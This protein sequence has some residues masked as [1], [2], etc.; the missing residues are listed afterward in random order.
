MI[1]R[2]MEFSPNNI[3]K[4]EH[5]G[6][7]RSFLGSSVDENITK[8]YADEHAAFHK[9]AGHVLPD[10]FL[11]LQTLHTAFWTSHSGKMLPVGLVRDLL[12]TTS[13]LNWRTPYTHEAIHDVSAVGQKRVM[14][15]SVHLRV[16]LLKERRILL[17]LCRSILL[18]EKLDDSHCQIVQNTMN[19]FGSNDP[20]QALWGFQMSK[21]SKHERK[22]T[23]PCNPTYHY[24]V[25]HALSSA[26]LEHRSRHDRAIFEAILFE[27]LNNVNLR[28]ES[29]QPKL[30][31]YPDAI[32]E[33]QRLEM[34][35]LLRLGN[36]S[37]ITQS[38]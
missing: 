15:A 23:K 28:I 21:T 29:H 33:L 4:N 18:E 31:E 26:H 12:A 35:R 1:G 9:L 3:E 2:S 22:Y 27:Q 11:R 13:D 19:F 16:L 34:E 10:A 36:R 25:S 32:R 24:D 37:F 5:H 14:M 7:P 20:I 6:V 38:S 8:L 30:E 17:N